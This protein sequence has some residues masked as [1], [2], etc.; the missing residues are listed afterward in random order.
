[1]SGPVIL[2]SPE[3][4]ERAD[5]RRFVAL[6]LRLLRVDLQIV[7]HPGGHIQRIGILYPV[8]MPRTPDGHDLTLKAFE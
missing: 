5:D 1:M 4:V 7:L 3:C 6:I 8:S 2:Y